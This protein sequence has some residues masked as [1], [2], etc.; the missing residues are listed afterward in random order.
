[1]EY[2]AGEILVKFRPGTDAATMEGVNG[3]IKATRIRELGRV[4]VQQVKLSPDM[5][6]EEAVSRYKEDPNVV[7]AEPNYI[8]RASV[9]PNDPDFSNLWG[10]NNTGQTGGTPDADLDAPEAWDLSTGSANVVIAVIDTGVAYN[11]PEL[12][13]NIWTNT[14]EIDCT[15]GV[16]DDLNGYID[17]CTGWDFIGDDNDPTDYNGHGTHVSGTIAAE[18]D[19]GADIA[20]VMWDARIMPLRFLGVS[21]AGDTAD[22]I[23]AIE[24]AAD[25]GAR[26]INASWGGGPYSQSL[27]DAIEY[28]RT[29]NVIFVA[30]AGNEAN[31]NDTSPAYPASYDLEN[32]ISVAAVDDADALA[33][34]SNYGLTSVDLGAPGVGIYSTVPVFSYGTPVILYTTDFNSDTAGNLPSGW[35]SGGTNDT[36]SVTAGTGVGGTNSLEDSPA[37]DYVSNTY[38]W[39]GYMTPISSVKDNRYMLSFQWEGYVDSVTGD[40]LN[41]NYSLDGIS[42]DWIDWTN[43]NTGGVFVPVSSDAFTVA[44]DMFSNFYFGFGMESYAVGNYDGVYIDDV[45]LTREPI[46]ISGYS[47]ATWSGTSMA[48]P[49]VSGVAGLLLSYSPLLTYTQVKDIMLGTVVPISSLSGK[50]VTGGRVNAFNALLGAVPPSAPA[51]L[52]ASAASSAG[53]INLA[54]TDNSTNETGFSIER[55]TGAGSFAEIATVGANATT[56][57]NTGLAEQTTYTYRVRAYNA[58]GDSAYSNEA[59]ATTTLN[60]PAG[61]TASAASSSQIN[62]MWTDNSGVE[63][64]FRIER[65]TG[66]GSFAEIAT[67]GANATT[68]SNTGLAEQTTYTYRLRAYSALGNSTYSNEASATTLSASSGGGG[69]GGGGCFIATAAYGSYLAP[70]VNVLKDFRDDHLLTNAAGRKFVELYYRY[71]PPIADYIARNEGLRTLTRIALTPIVYGVKYPSIF[72]LVPG[73]I[74]LTFMR[75]RFTLK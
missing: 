33:S 6:V 65:K 43:G 64:G 58:S 59:S 3:A 55:K 2:V 34:F 52:T 72:I 73:F 1:M 25:N 32:I 45:L 13:N 23:V 30:A 69:G 26:V 31:D 39:A 51:G 28:A 11:H 27:Y 42:W 12:I 50:T 16:D 71:S 70:E 40:Y 48:T 18:G 15:D 24:Y 37:A 53:Q 21:G 62:L 67:V 17:D 7:Y 68:Y 20:G 56:Y 66:A 46:S 47:Y 14:G 60:A 36:W 54:W 4:G 9:I 35:A 49:H 74:L 10:L 29:K 41:I 5:S 57:S 63:T 75:R 22:A 19:N 61:L 8:L 44:A 38:S